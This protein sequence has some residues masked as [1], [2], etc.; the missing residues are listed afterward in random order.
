MKISC[1]FGIN[2]FY[3]LFF[4]MVVYIGFMGATMENG[5]DKEKFYQENIELEKRKITLYIRE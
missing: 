3:S 2:I 5:F 4:L 1:K